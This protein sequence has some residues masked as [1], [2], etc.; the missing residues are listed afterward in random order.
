MN[1]CLWHPSEEEKRE[2]NSIAWV[3]VDKGELSDILS[4]SFVI[5]AREHNQSSLI[6]SQGYPLNYL[7]TPA[8]LTRGK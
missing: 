8:E 4:A 1:I 3:K 2:E 6:F 5:K 7:K